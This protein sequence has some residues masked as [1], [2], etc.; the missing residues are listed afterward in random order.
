MP[1]D[2]PFKFPC[3]FPVK[4][5]GHNEQS[6]RDEAWSIVSSHY[7]DLQPNQV[8]EKVSRD[9]KYVSMTFTVQARDKAGLD[10]LYRELSANPQVVMAL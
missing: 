2:A 10:E 4:V 7:Q 6:F 8:A 9:G 5:F 3:A 1:K